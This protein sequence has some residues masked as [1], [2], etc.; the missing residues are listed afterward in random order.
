MG[1]GLGESPGY[2]SGRGGISLVNRRSSPEPGA[3][4]VHEG[5]PPE[6]GVGGLISRTQAL[7]PVR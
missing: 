4:Y 3:S 2:A 5:S 6:P 1:A 7:H